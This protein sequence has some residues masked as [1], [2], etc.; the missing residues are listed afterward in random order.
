MWT[1][2]T[3]NLR[4]Q[5]SYVEFSRLRVQVGGLETSGWMRKSLS[6]KNSVREEGEWDGKGNG[7]QWECT[8]RGSVALAWSWQKEGQG[9][10]SHTTVVCPQS[11][12]AGLTCSL[13]L[14]VTGLA[15]P[16][17]PSPFT[18]WVMGLLFV[19]NYIEK[20]TMGANSFQY[21]WQLGG[22]YQ[23]HRGDL[24]RVWTKN[25]TLGKSGRWA[26]NRVSLGGV[27]L[28][29]ICRKVLH[30]ESEIN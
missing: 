4:G 20:G 22:V 11:K 23:P 24:G 21:S 10:K 8:L 27:L 3:A 26:P 30:V 6:E 15:L 25:M 12:W 13:N 5:A 16:S 7:P 17:S 19:D 18:S 9:N 29:V 2:T 28:E 1:F 14:S